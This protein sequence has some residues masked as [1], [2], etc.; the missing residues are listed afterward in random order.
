[1]AQAAAILALCERLRKQS[2]KARN[3]ET[4]AD[5]RLATYYLR[6]LAVLKI[7]EEAEVETDPTR[8]QQLEHEASHAVAHS[9]QLETGSGGGMVGGAGRRALFRSFRTDRSGKAPSAEP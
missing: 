7:A 6:A 3:R 9:S 4:I 1:M 8:K 5:L 2:R